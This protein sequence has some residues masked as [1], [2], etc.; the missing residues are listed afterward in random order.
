ME[1]FKLPNTTKV[2][3]IV[4]KNAFDIYATSKQK[5]LFTELVSRIIWL[6]KLSPDTVNL[7]AKEVKE[8]QILKIELKA[9]KDIQDV[10]N[11]IDKSI[12]YN[13]IFIVEFETEIFLSTSIKHS[14]PVNY[15]NA[16]IDWTFK[17]EWF[18]LQ[19][20]EY[21]L[22]LKKSLDSV[23]HDFCLQLSNYNFAYNK[24]FEEFIELSKTIESLRRE[25]NKL[26]TAI[27]N[28]KQFKS[29]VE[30]NILLSRKLNELNLLLDKTN[31]NGK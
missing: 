13:I 11:V 6:H 10:L 9:K 22:L 3:R 26:K 30:L 7:E 15:D 2:Q 20:K 21:Q 29:K 1:Y 27:T 25:I 5:R 4:P 18:R 8:I 17:T 16:V 24:P 19:E 14:N 23:Y 12:P 28:C 31:A